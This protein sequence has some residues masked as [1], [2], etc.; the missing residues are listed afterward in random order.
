MGYLEQKIS[1]LLYYSKMN[2]TLQLSSILGVDW[3]KYQKGRESY[4]RNNMVSDKYIYVNLGSV[5][6]Q[7]ILWLCHKYKNKFCSWTLWCGKFLWLPSTQIWFT[8]WSRFLYSISGNHFL[9]EINTRNKILYKNG[10]WVLQIIILRGN[11]TTLSSNMPGK[12]RNAIRLFS[13]K[14]NYDSL[15][16]IE[17]AWGWNKNFNKR[18]LLQVSDHNVCRWRLFYDLREER[19]NPV[20][21]STATTTNNSGWLEWRIKII[22][23]LYK[24]GERILASY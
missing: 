1:G 8:Q 10:V 14:P 23:R 7:P 2:P 24:T 16:K 18:G 11:Y 5:T 17:G 12:Q 4:H 9:F 22:G 13:E 20:G 19:R 21:R 3:W 15:L 6:R